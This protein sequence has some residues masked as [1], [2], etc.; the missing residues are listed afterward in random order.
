MIDFRIDIAF[1]SVEIIIDCLY[2]YFFF[3]PKDSNVFL[4]LGFI[5]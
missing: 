3:N 1:F 4:F 2:I 5:C